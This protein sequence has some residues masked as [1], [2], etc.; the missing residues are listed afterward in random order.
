MFHE[1]DVNYMIEMK[2]ND[3]DDGW[4]GAIEMVFSCHGTDGYTVMAGQR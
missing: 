2:S 1:W 4:H 3:N